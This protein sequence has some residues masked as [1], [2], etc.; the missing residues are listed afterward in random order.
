ML[1]GY[2]GWQTHPCLARNLHLL[3]QRYDRMHGRLPP[4]EKILCALIF[5]AGTALP[6]C[7]A[8][9]FARSAWCILSHSG[10][11][12]LA[13][14]I[15]GAVIVGLGT[16][17]MIEI[18]LEMSRR[19]PAP[20]VVVTFAILFLPEFYALATAVLAAVRR[21]STFR[22]DAFS[23]I[24]CFCFLLLFL[25]DFLFYSQ[26][27]NRRIRRAADLLKPF[28]RKKSYDV[29]KGVE[30]ISR[31]VHSERVLARIAARGC[32]IRYC[33]AAVEKLS[34][35]RSMLAEAARKAAPST[36]GAAA[37]KVILR[38]LAEEPS[39]DLLIGRLANEA[40]IPDLRIDAVKAL[41]DQSAIR[42]LATQPNGPIA[43]RCIAIGKLK[44]EDLSE[45]IAQEDPDADARIS[46]IETINRQPVLL[47]IASEDRDFCVRYAAAALLT[48]EFGRT[49]AKQTDDYA[50]CEYLIDTLP[51]SSLSMEFYAEFCRAKCEPAY[52]RLQIRILEKLWTPENAEAIV[53]A[54][55]KYSDGQNAKYAAVALKRIYKRS[56]ECG[57]RN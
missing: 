25:V 40:K 3:L 33:L 20:L 22:A 50:I 15:F 47:R 8:G 53:G 32:N 14:R 1:I 26:R 2:Q 23:A 13:E 30:R 52:E 43:V 6:L 38:K 27:M 42:A 39:D 4:K 48:P 17:Y 19:R 46:A 37:A 55:N 9:M 11:V 7:A 21:R 54:L 56:G 51:T 24:L 12:F 35:N 28:W 18:L 49:L 10:T 5:F 36:P 44:D 34:D 29:E 45:R 57:T 16:V 31:R 41:T